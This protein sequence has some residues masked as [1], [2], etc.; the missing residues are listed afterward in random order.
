VAYAVLFTAGVIH[1]HPQ[2]KPGRA[3]EH[4][5]LFLSFNSPSL[6][7]KL[8]NKTFALYIIL[9][10]L[11]LA[12]V[13]CYKLLNLTHANDLNY[14]AESPYATWNVLIDKLS[15]DQQTTNSNYQIPETACCYRPACC[16]FA[17]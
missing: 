2:L 12:A 10:S 6:R 3:G 17:P 11:P 9:F 15:F 5:P 1:H 8:V 13:L 16:C 4:L 7:R 14:F